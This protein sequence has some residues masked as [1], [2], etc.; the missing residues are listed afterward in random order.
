MPYIKSHSNYALK[1]KH[2]LVNDGTVFERDITTI[3]AVNQFA[4]GQTPIYRSGN[5]IITVRGDRGGANQYNT[6]KWEQNKGGETWTLNNI[7]DMVSNDENQNDTKIVLKNDYYD[8]RDFA[9]YGSLTELFR[10]SMNDILDRFPGEL[11]CI[12]GSG[13]VGAVYYTSSYTVDLEGVENSVRLGGNNNLY[14]IS[15]PYG[16]NIHSKEAPKDADPLK[17]FANEGYKKYTFSGSPITSWVVTPNNNACKPG[18][19]VADIII[20]NSV[21]VY[22]YLGNNG[23]VYYLHAAAQNGVHIAPAGDVITEFYNGCNDFERIILN[24]NTSPMYKATFSVI[25]ENDYGYYRELEEFIFPTSD[26]GY[27]PATESSYIDRLVAIGE[28]YD[29]NLTD[30]LYRSMTHEAIKNFD[31]S[32]TR[33]YDEDAEEEHFEGGQK[34]QK[35]LRIFAREFDEQKKYID[36]IKNTGRISYDE[37]ANIPD[38]FLADVCEDDGW[39]IKSV[40]PYDMKDMSSYSVERLLSNVEKTCLFTEFKTNYS[41][42]F[43]FIYR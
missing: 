31:W 12:S 35:A 2:Q 41:T 39:D 20:N 18:D 15:N 16:I 11:Y 6:Q 32:Y 28:F 30:N 17:Y 43:I 24:P 5:F 37:R 42:L 13:E 40:I 19:K 14:E 23:N 4:P 27:N 8:L 21:T 7:A 25:K 38:Y 1:K 34:I 33:E 9:Y 3:G 10:S 29:E 36:N 22:A 26:G